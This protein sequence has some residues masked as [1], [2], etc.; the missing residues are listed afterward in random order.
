MKISLTL[1]C[2]GLLTSVVTALP[3]YA[4]GPPAD[5]CS[6]AYALTAVTLLQELAQQTPD[7]YFTEMDANGDG[8][9][10][11]KFL[12][13]ASTNVGIVHDNHVAGF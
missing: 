2:A 1:V 4:A 3:A 11:N 13:D 10:C 6:R 7:S 9:L 8:Y 12:P 5:G